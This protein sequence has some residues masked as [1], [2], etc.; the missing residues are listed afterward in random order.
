MTEPKPKSVWRPILPVPA[1]A[2]KVPNEHKGRGKPH[3]IYEYLNLN[4]E[5]LGF[6]WMF[7]TS[8]G[9]RALLPM[10]WCQDQ[11]GAREWRSIQF[12]RL[13]PIFGIETLAPSEGGLRLATFAGEAVAPMDVQRD[14]V[15]CFDAHAAEE[16]RRILPFAS[17]SW[18]GGIGNIDEVDW[19]QLR[20]HKSVWIWP[21]KTGDRMKV[22]TEEEGEGLLMT[23]DKQSAWKAVRKLETHLVGLGVSIMG[24]IDPFA[25]DTVP[26]GFDAAMAASMGWTEEQTMDWFFAHLCLGA[27][28]DAV[29]KKWRALKGEADPLVS[30]ETAA[31]EQSQ[32]QAKRLTWE[33]N[34]NRRYGEL[35]GCLANV[36]DILKHDP[37]W[38]GVIAYNEFSLRTVKR[39]PAPSGGDASDW[40]D[41]DDTRA[42]MW[43]TRKYGITPSSDIVAKAVETLAD[44]NRWN[45]VLEWL[46]SLKWDETKRLN[47]W[48]ATAGGVVDSKYTR[49]VAA[50]WLMGAVKRVLQPGCKFDYC[51]VLQGEQGK[52]K[53]TIFSILGGE[54]FGDTELDF[55]NKDSI[56]L[57]AGKLIYEF[58]ELGALARADE[59]RQ[60]AFLTRQQDEY[61]PVYGRRITRA[62]R[63]V[64]FGG[65]TNEWEWNKDP[66]GGRR[67]WPVTC[68]G[69]LDHAWL[70]EWRDQLFAEAYVR[71]QAGER[72]HP[73]PEEQKA[74]FDPE[75]LRIEQQNSY[76]DLLHDFVWDPYK[77]DEL[78]SLA[79]AAAYMKIPP[80]RLNAQTETKIGIA[81]KKLGCTREEF[82]NGITR[83][84][85][86]RPQKASSSEARSPQKNPTLA[87]AGEVGFVGMDMEGEYGF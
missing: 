68:V 45:P 41:A 73:T 57:L 28:T 67:F 33:Q 7:F 21:T 4:G 56:A 78:F 58:P 11:D 31:E 24:V 60:K 87:P 29:Q 1:D 61:R 39:K 15:I 18:P 71:V 23:R 63:Q 12:Q 17:I 54:W 9:P 84:K 74:L 22:R 47:T 53:S 14:V 38:Q 75:Q 44:G 43:L 34:L 3:A 51:L 26:I 16:A 72:M 30:A 35:T 62:P 86:K 2:F 32:Q 49:R 5:L 48:L 66:T 10:T 85:Y 19:A 65:S 77:L 81:L 82:R 27:G 40:G 36:H 37:E 64:V 70:R 80:D 20:G 46:Q 8:K 69:E 25:D 42:A 79:E 52:G 83:Y 6:E 50:W 55:G 13:R 59:R 76:V